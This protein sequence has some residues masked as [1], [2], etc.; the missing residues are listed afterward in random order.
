MSRRMNRETIQT[1]GRRMPTDRLDNKPYRLAD[2][3]NSKFL[4]TKPKGLQKWL[5]FSR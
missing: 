3:N 2:P 4:L 5:L 1:S